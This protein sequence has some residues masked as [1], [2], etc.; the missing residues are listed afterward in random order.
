VTCDWEKL[1]DKIFGLRR[2]RAEASCHS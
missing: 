2:H 1:L